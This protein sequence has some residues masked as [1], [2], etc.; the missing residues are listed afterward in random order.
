MVT[1]LQISITLLYSKETKLNQCL[2]GLC[3]EIGIELSILQEQKLNRFYELLIEKNKVMNLTTITEYNEVVLKHFIDS[4]M[5]HDKLDM[6]HVKHIM[7]VGTGGGFP[8]I[9]L[10]IMYPEINITLLDSLNKRIN[11]LKEVQKELELEYIECIHG[12]AEE[13][14]HQPGY[15]EQYDLVVSRA[16][17]N[18]SSLCEFC[19][20]FVKVG[21]VFVSYKSGDI[22]EELRN[23]ANAIHT[24]KAKIGKVVKYQLPGTD[25]RRSMIIIEKV[26]HISNKYPRKPGTPLKQPL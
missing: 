20:P 5:I 13:I 21:G 9:P 19:I 2:K 4:L 11:F 15:R 1:V 22:D 6:F 14:A 3:K 25:I 24:L 17:A 16:V 18:L 7:D 12:R 8:G 23:A 10:K 26:G